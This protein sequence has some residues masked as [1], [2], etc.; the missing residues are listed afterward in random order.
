MWLALALAAALWSLR[1]VWAFTIDDA[2]ISY[3]Y[4]KHL[5]EGQG[6]VAVVGG[7]WVEGYSNPLWVF[8]L[9][10]LHALGLDLPVAGKWLG[11]TLFALGL[12]AGSALISLVAGRRWWAFGA[13]EMSFVI[14]SALCLELAVW[15]PAGLENA[16]FGALLLALLLLDARESQTPTAF[17]SSGLVAFALAIT[18]PEGALYAAPLVLIKLGRALARREPMR[19]ALTATT[20]FVLLFLLYHAG[21][22]LVFGQLVPNTYWAKPP[23]KTWTRG[24]EYLGTTLRESGLLYALP[25]ALI[26]LYGK[27]RLKL[28]VGWTALA[29][30]MFVVYSGGDWMPNGRFLSLFAPALLVLAALGLEHVARGAA[31]LSR[32]RLPSEAAACA[33]AGML[34]LGWL[35]Y[36]GPRLAALHEKGWCHFCERV[37]DTARVRRLG[38]RA[39][40]PSQSFLTHDFGGPSWLSEDGF[41]PIDFLGLCDR[42]AALLRYRRAAGSVGYDLR[43]YQYFIH[44]QP[45]PPSWVLVPPNFWPRFDRSPEAVLDYYALPPRLLPRIRR[46]AFFV[47]SRAELVD[48]FPPLPAAD[49][50]PLPERLALVGFAPF[51][52]P[53]AQAAT[54]GPGV[55]VRFVV[56][57][58]PQSALRG[59]ERIGVRVEAAGEH[60]DSELVSLDRGLVGLARALT[61]GEPLALELDVTLPRAAADV[62]QLSLGVAPAARE[63]RRQGPP[64]AYT[65]LATLPLGATLPALE[66]SLPRYP[67]ALPTPL[68]PELIRLRPAVTNVVDRA[69][70][71]GHAP[72]EAA[73]SRELRELAGR[74]EARGDAAQAYLA[75]VWATQVRRRSWE[76]LADSVFRLRPRTLDDEH[77]LEITLLRRYYRTTRADELGRLI[78]FY[79]S[80]GRGP[81]ADYFLRRWPAAERDSEL[82][83]AL[84]VAR[85]R[86]LPGAG[87][88]GREASSRLLELVAFDPLGGALDFEGPALAGWDGTAAAFRV[89]LSADRQVV[90]GLRGQHGAGVLSSREGGE[91]ARGALT[92]P[93]FR[94]DGRQLSLLVAGG[95]RSR[96]VGVELL[97]DGAV[98]FSASGNDSDNLLPVFW[99]IT[100]FAG[101][102]ARLRVFD[103]SARDHVLLDRV[104]VWR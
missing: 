7:P 49:L 60:A 54:L 53:T 4:A 44:E 42:S 25:L 71:S 61:P 86:E 88:A 78:G 21:H 65:P 55:R 45:T 46:D 67:S 19:Q 58:V 17:A 103:D 95:S 12:G 69:R 50:L 29:G 66:R 98:A 94:L 37:A 100:P 38:Q 20:L 57:V 80:L 91:R 3:A 31:A 30:V 16:L 48:Y 47:L 73:L 82:E 81:E 72:S 1:A 79:L 75:S 18:R 97:V 93:E 2:G 59:G 39:G 90:L 23:G 11:A 6:P 70:R 99:D 83:R 101:K 96:H 64:P 9:V 89:E 24:L 51:A 52:E 8:L 77:A 10:P 84:R 40:L 74:L 104:L 41:Y 35:D 33:G 27:P 28:L 26:G 63:A 43:L 36:Q 85:G 34:A 14:A 76:E 102:S 56:S 87:S 5:A 32:T 92:S 68:E 62:Y 15:V 13:A 22:Y